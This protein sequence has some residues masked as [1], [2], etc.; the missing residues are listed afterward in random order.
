[1]TRQLRARTSRPNYATLA[2]LEDEDGAGPSNATYGFE[3][4]GS[5]SDFTPDA[6]HAEQED[7][8]DAEVDT[9]LDAGELD[10][11]ADESAAPA[12]KKRGGAVS[13]RELSFADFESASVGPRR[14]GTASRAAP[15]RTV[16][17]PGS[18]YQST[19]QSAS[20]ML[21]SLNH[22]H[23]SVA[24]H[25][26][27]GK[28][29]RL[30]REPL[31]LVTEETTLANAWGSSPV[32]S[33][34]VNKS[35]GYNVGPGPLWEIVED[36]GWFKEAYD[37]PRTTEKEMRPRVH[38][39]VP[40]GD[41]EILNEQYVLHLPM[42]I[43]RKLTGDNYSDSITYIP[44]DAPEAKEGSHKPSPPVACSF[45]PFGKQTRLELQT[46][47]S[48]KMGSWTCK[49][50]YMSELT[51]SQNSS[52]PAA[53]RMCSMLAGPFGV[54]IGV[55]FIQI[56]EHVSQIILAAPQ[57]I[58]STHMNRET[59]PTISRCITFPHPRSHP[60]NWYSCSTTESSLHPNMELGSV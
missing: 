27:S 5:G 39:G 50:G 33:E 23:R 54:L 37:T 4:D 46:F 12:K 53:K 7:H 57:H 14:G 2:G 1:M 60:H 11:D 35:W 48:I 25:K 43:S 58:I 59:E 3:S 9:A 10:D 47:T 52:S 8:D 15:K 26:R 42:C 32:I 56:T 20:S 6:A 31:P 17:I 13:A 36:R 22:R 41:Y 19:K 16:S 28:T 24:L 49:H 18:T 55:Q 29:E 34:R 38:E 45:G 51:S 44:H 40:L 21:P 30:V